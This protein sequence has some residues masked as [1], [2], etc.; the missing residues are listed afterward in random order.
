MQLAYEI[1][2]TAGTLVFNQERFNE[3][4]LYQTGPDRRTNGFRTILSGPAHEGY[5]GF[6]PAAG[7]QIGFNDMKAIE[8][9]RFIECVGAGRPA[10]PDFRWAAEVQDVIDAMALSGRERCWVPVGRRAAV[11]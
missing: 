2:G 4:G 5:S 7:H 9:A 1:T 3:L 6:L 8:M 11:D 10:F